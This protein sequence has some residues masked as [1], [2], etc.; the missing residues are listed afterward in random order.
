M[1]ATTG[2]GPNQVIDLD[3]EPADPRELAD[4]GKVHLGPRLRDAAVDPQTGD[5]LVP[6]NAGQDNPH[7][8]RVVAPGLHG[9]RGT[10]PIRPGPVSDD[11]AQQDADERELTEAIYVN[12]ELVQDAVA[13]VAPDPPSPGQA[14]TVIGQPAGASARAANGTSDTTSP[15][16]IARKR[17]D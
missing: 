3:P 5:H 14:A 7:G 16:R 1:P 2:G 17:I 6:T 8:R 11:P 9:A 4:G 15:T 12:G 13:A 10:G